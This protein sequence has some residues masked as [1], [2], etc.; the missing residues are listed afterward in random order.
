LY[1]IN[2]HELTNPEGKG[3]GH[4]LFIGNRTS[5]LSHPYGFILIF[6]FQS[7]FDYCELTF[8]F[9]WAFTSRTPWTGY[10]CI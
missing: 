1:A 7:Y 4:G 9:W 2:S 10:T 5:I 8:C 6:S 3:L